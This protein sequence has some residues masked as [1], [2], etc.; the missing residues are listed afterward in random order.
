[1]TRPDE[2]IEPLT[3]GN[4]RSLGVRWLYA[5]CQTCGHE[6][7]V[8]VDGWPDAGKQSRDCRGPCRSNSSSCFSLSLLN[9]ARGR[10]RRFTGWC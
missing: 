10:R 9:P 1:M 2:P 8:N 4:M 7:E 3:L 5:T 6:T